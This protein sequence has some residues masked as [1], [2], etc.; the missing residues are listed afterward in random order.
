MTFPVFPGKHALEGM[1]SPDEMLAHRRRGGRLPAIAPFSGAVI[2]LQRG[3]PERLGRRVRLRRLGRLMGDL[4][5]VR[6]TNGRVAVLTNLGL[7][8]PMVAAQAEE[9]IA[10]GAKR[11]VSVALSGALQP[12]LAP[13]TVVIASRAI[14]DEGTSHHY[15]APAR[16]ISADPG[17]VAALEGALTASDPSLRVGSTWSTDAPYRETREEVQAYQAE[18]VLT[19]DMELAALL[20]VAESRGVAAAGVLIVGDS[21]AGGRWHAPE[22]LDGME[23]AL[24][25]AYRAAIGVLDAG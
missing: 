20:S 13:G 15:L 18:G 16:D 25:R 8:A 3:L 5:A 22:R 7:G 24:E 11:I 10:L 2:C 12:D 19:V 21:L 4:Y 23:R 14:R 9:L 6:S 1:V 17:L